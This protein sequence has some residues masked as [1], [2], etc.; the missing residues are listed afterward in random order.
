MHAASQNAS[1]TSDPQTIE[2]ETMKVTIHEIEYKATPYGRIATI[3]AGTPCIPAS[4]LPGDDPGYW[5]EPWDGMDEKA[6]SWIGCYGF[7][8]E[9][10]EVQDR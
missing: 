2:D 9:S 10:H 5:V 6:E 1:R 7:H 4:N 8:V 3:P